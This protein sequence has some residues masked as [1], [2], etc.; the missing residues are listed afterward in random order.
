MEIIFRSRNRR[1]KRFVQ[2]NPQEEISKLEFKEIV[3]LAKATFKK[4]QSN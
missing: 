3:A 4:S 2:K 1:E